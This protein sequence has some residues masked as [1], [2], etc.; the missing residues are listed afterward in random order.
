MVF[1]AQGTHPLDI[2]DNPLVAA[3]VMKTLIGSF[4][5]VLVA[6]LTA[7]AAGALFARRTPPERLTSP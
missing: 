3:E 4:A 6:P 7:V 5:L 2:L 1:A